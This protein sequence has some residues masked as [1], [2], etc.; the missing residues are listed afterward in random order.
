MSSFR[1]ALTSCMHRGGLVSSV[2]MLG[3]LSAGCVGEPGGD[4]DEESPSIQVE[5]LGEAQQAL[6]CVTIKRGVFGAV[7]DAQISR[8]IG[9]SPVLDPEGKSNY[10]ALPSAQVGRAAPNV[11]RK[12]LLRFDLSSIPRAAW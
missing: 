4:D 6:S 1:A 5:S 10:G 8:T 11:A 2:A 9:V 3:V 7:R 12:T